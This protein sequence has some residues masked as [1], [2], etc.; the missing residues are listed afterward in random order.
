MRHL[1]EEH[2]R[3]ISLAH[4]GKMPKNIG[5]LNELAKQRKGKP[6]KQFFPKDELSYSW[7]GDNVGY[8]AI[9]KWV[10]RKLGK[11]ICCSV[12]PNHKSSAFQWSN[13][14]G[15]YKRDLKDFRSL[16]LSCHQKFDKNRKFRESYSI[17]N[18]YD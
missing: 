8:S 5:L 13:I 2:K 16:C 7:K 6:S 18:F 9:H 4:K 11:A 12:N 17:L 10:T 14:S 15:T 3:N 1:S